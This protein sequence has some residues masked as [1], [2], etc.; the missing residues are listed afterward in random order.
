M[1]LTIELPVQTGRVLRNLTKNGSETGGTAA[2]SSNPG[3]GYTFRFS[4]CCGTLSRSTYVYT[5]WRYIFAR[6]TKMILE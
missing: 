4:L 5:L 1:T 3:R 2:V 6:G